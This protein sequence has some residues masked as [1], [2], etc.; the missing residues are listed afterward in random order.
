MGRVI[1]VGIIVF[2]LIYI[3]KTICDTIKAK[4]NRH[5]RR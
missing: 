5:K 3:T 1:I 2:G 4:Y